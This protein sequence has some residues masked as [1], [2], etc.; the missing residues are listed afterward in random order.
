MANYNPYQQGG[1]Q[2]GPPSQS[3]FTPNGAQNQYG[4]TPQTGYGHPATPQ[5]DQGYFPPQGQANVGR[6]GGMA[7]LAGQFGG[8]GLGG[9]AA[10]PYRP[11]KKKNRHAYHNL[12]QSSAPAPTFGGPSQGQLGY[13]NTDN[14]QHLG[15]NHP[16]AGQQVTPQMSQFPAP[17]NAPFSPGLQTPSPGLSAQP[18]P[19]PPSTGPGISQGKVDPE[20]IPSIPRLRDAATQYYL[21][22]VYPTMEQ[23]IPPPAAVPFVAHDQ[24]NSSPKHARLTLNNIP[25]TSEALASTALPL[26]IVLQPLAPPQD[27]EQAIPVLDFGD[28]GP[29]RCR[30]CRTYINPFMIFRSGGNKLVCNMCT[31]P[32][33]VSPEYFAPT[34][35][36]GV[37]VDRPQRPELTMGTV[38]FMV[39]K[40]YWAKEPVGLHWIFLIDVGQEAIQRGFLQAFCEGVLLSLYGNESDEENI[41]QQNGDNSETLRRIPPGCKVGFA[42]FD[43]SMYFFNCNVSVPLSCISSGANTTA[44]QAGTSADVGNA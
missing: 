26:G 7:A 11:H 37:R 41:E 33:D 19:I 29:P 6:D 34:D 1:F 18:Q 17:P 31:F 13:A 4:G 32:N 8:M 20:Q 40:E 28:T 23:H 3:L 27:G 30:R 38:E 21:E 2:Q 15:A 10:A 42:T 22:N 36:S 14:T 5:Q 43:R 16:Y 35:P 9:D 24:G 12:E 44:G 39:P 25:S